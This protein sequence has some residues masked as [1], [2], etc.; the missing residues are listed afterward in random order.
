MYF[1]D[2]TKVAGFDALLPHVELI[3]YFP[4]DR[5]ITRSITVFLLIVSTPEYISLS[6]MNIKYSLI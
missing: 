6:S 4:S 1:H 5:R 3:N 2:W